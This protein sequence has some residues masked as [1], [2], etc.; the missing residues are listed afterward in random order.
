MDIYCGCQRAGP[1]SRRKIRSSSFWAD[2]R[3]FAREMQYENCSC[4]RTSLT[5][6]VRCRQRISDLSL[7]VHQEADVVSRSPL[8]Q[9]IPILAP[10]QKTTGRREMNARNFARVAVAALGGILTAT[11]ALAQTQPATHGPAEGGSP[12]WFLQ[13]SFPDPGGN[14]VVDPGGRVTI[15]P[16]TGGAATPPAATTAASSLPRTPA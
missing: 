2:D 7:K 14:T 15:P 5:V 8:C 16:R 9:D 1:A 4:D 13:G 12:A 11:G 10:N 3:I 6:S